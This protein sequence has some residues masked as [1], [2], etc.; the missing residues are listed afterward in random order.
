MDQSKSNEKFT[1]QHAKN[2]ILELLETN[3]SIYYL[4]EQS[5]LQISA[6]RVLKWQLKICQSYWNILIQTQTNVDN[7]QFYQLVNQA[8][9]LNIINR[10]LKEEWIKKIMDC[11]VVPILHSM[12]LD[13]V[14]DYDSPIFTETVRNSFG[15]VN[16]DE[17]KK[18]VNKKENEK[19]E[20]DSDSEVEVDEDYV[21]LPDIKNLSKVNIPDVI[22]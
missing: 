21:L 7:M 10:K 19:K 20:E 11:F 22:I 13:T 8:L 12:V 9:R 1:I 4:C 15:I 6:Y 17:E 5:K 18:T 3:K 14:R 16:Y 2:L